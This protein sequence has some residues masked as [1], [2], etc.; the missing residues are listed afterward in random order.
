MKFPFAD[1]RLRF[2]H[3][4]IIEARTRQY[5]RDSTYMFL[6]SEHLAYKAPKS[7]SFEVG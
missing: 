5:V 2:T 4:D 1:P 7:I 6:C 3:F